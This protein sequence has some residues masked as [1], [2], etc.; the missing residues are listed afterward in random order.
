MQTLI[1]R[2]LNS[3]QMAQSAKRSLG[4]QLNQAL[5]LGLY[6]VALLTALGQSK[7]K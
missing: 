3:E 5:A 6:L 7:E 4:L 2:R 1:S